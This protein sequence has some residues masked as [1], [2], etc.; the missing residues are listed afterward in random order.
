MDAGTLRPFAQALL[1]LPVS[2]ADL[3]VLATGHWRDAVDLVRNKRLIALVD[4]VHPEVALLDLRVQWLQTRDTYSHGTWLTAHVR[5][6]LHM[7][8]HARIHP[9][10]IPDSHQLVPRALFPRA[11]LCLNERALVDT[12][13]VVTGLDYN[14]RA[15]SFTDR[16]N[17]HHVLSKGL[18]K[19]C[20]IRELAKFLASYVRQDPLVGRSISTMLAY[21][22]C[23]LYS[24]CKHR[25]PM[26]SMTTIVA[27]L[28]LTPAPTPAFL[29]WLEART[30]SDPRH[31]DNQTLCSYVI[32]EYL[33]VAVRSCPP[34]C[35]VLHNQIG[36]SRFETDT[37]EAMEFVRAALCAR[38]RGRHWT[39]YCTRLLE[40]AVRE[41]DRCEQRRSSPKTDL[42]R[43]DVPALV[44]PFG[45]VLK[46]FMA[47]RKLHIQQFEPH[48]QRDMMRMQID[49]MEA[50]ASVP[51][52]VCGIVNR[53]RFMQASEK[54]IS[55]ANFVLGMCHCHVKVLVIR[56]CMQRFLL[57]DVH[58]YSMFEHEV[59][60][61][62]EQ[63]RTEVHRLPEHL[64]LAQTATI[65]QVWKCVGG[66][67]ACPHASAL[68]LCTSC[69]MVKVAVSDQPDGSAKK[70]Q[71]MLNIASAHV[72]VDTDACTMLCARSHSSKGSAARMYKKMQ[73]VLSGE[74]VSGPFAA[75]AFMSLHTTLRC[76]SRAVTV[77]PLCGNI[78]RHNSDLYSMCVEC[79]R[80]MRVCQATMN[81]IC[82]W[83][84]RS[85]AGSLAKLAAICVVCRVTRGAPL[86]MVTHT[87]SKTVVQRQSVCAKCACLTP[88]CREAAVLDTDRLKAVLVQKRLFLSLRLPGP[89]TTFAGTR[90]DPRRRQPSR[91]GRS[92]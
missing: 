22:L 27:E 77:I 18:P 36:W 40:T 58:G 1:V 50:S 17:L 7:Q 83:C 34:L 65:E 59:R 46:Q 31:Y 62:H 20:Q 39:Q 52:T 87:D 44:D 78:V 60:S 2:D 45:V 70:D 28:M 21:S 13:S 5:A 75:T 8:T 9:G 69:G 35:A 73:S 48:A 89:V 91:S 63:T 26:G 4:P 33:C 67:E 53:M 51:Q 15:V 41:V 11:E 90:S 14:S 16:T 85:K 43:Q 76:K 54:A 38:H 81:L 24:H 66:V 47:L 10:A 19:R 56:N 84:Q 3:V 37:I 61:L 29:A 32:R 23:G 82:Y 68:M 74:S 55:Y 57:F 79:A 86:M 12:R 92:L 42:V 6:Y 80:V 72:V 30:G 49:I 71:F 64:A 25:L 88:R